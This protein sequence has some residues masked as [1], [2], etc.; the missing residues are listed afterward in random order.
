[1]SLTLNHT[2]LQLSSPTVLPAPLAQL[3]T[4]LTTHL[5]LGITA[6]A[7]LTEALLEWWRN[8]VLL[9]LEG[10]RLFGEGVMLVSIQDMRQ[11]RGKETDGERWG[12]AGIHFVHT[13]L[14]LVELF[15]LTS[16]HVVQACVSGSLNLAA[17]SAQNLELI[18]GNSDASRAIAAIVMVCRR[19]FSHPGFGYDK[20]VSSIS[21]MRKLVSGIT[22]FAVLQNKVGVRGARTGRGEVIASVHVP[23]RK[24]MTVAGLIGDVPRL[25]GNDFDGGPLSRSTTYTEDTMSDS[26]VDCASTSEMMGE[27]DYYTT[28][29]PSPG[30]TFNQSS[31]YQSL[32]SQLAVSTPERMDRL[33]IRLVARYMRHS[34][35]AYGSAFLRI[36]GLSTPTA[37]AKSPTAVEAYSIHARIPPQAVIESSYTPGGAG[38]GIV[39]FISA[40]E[41]AR[42]VVLTCRGTLG[43]GDLI[44]DLTADYLPYETSGG[45]G[46][47]HKGMVHA[48]ERLSTGV[49]RSLSEALK[50]RPGYG[51][52]LCG[53]S[54][55]GGVS[56]L[57][58][59]KW[60]IPNAEGEWIINP[61]GPLPMGRRVSV[62]A[63]GPPAAVCPKL[64]RY[65]KGLVTS[66]VND[67]DVVPCL[68]WGMIRDAKNVALELSEAPEVVDEIRRRA[69]RSSQ[70]ATGL[71]S[72][73][74]LEMDS[75]C[76][77]EDWFLSVIK[78]L[79]AVMTS[80]KLVPPG[81]VLQMQ[82]ERRLDGETYVVA[83]QLRDVEDCFGEVKFT[84]AMFISHSPKEY[85]KML[86]IL[87][88]ASTGTERN[89]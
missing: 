54:L 48:A 59:L 61:G 13:T 21:T 81:D 2:Q 46:W 69:L 41:S 24:T 38:E 31:K 14:S 71:S 89:E 72:S 44:A 36:L 63:Y 17:L 4:T 49:L 86:H 22:W 43:L 26:A 47:A 35:A 12:R 73:K 32:A 51:L 29:P 75:A 34:S 74:L 8:G 67:T 40:D 57:L 3:V 15:N 45:K 10:I 18:F 53:H 11:I 77:D 58:G 27:P 16:V 85:E 87:E 50:A 5:S 1:M 42:N 62:Y 70:Y 64:A 83:R 65:A 25:N 9:A 84:K 23:A 56:A 55:G 28:A 52:V 88:R 19:E 7:I 79:R 78:T 30:L 37:Y 80:D 20:D 33:D 60:A 6:T 66:V 68:S 76:D 82:S 39:W